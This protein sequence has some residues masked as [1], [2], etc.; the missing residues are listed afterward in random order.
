MIQRYEID[1]HSVTMYEVADGGYVKWDDVKD[2]LE[3]RDLS[4]T[5]RPE[6]YKWVDV[7]FKEDSCCNRGSIEDNVL[8]VDCGD[9]YMYRDN[10]YN[11][12][13]KWKY[14]SKLDNPWEKQ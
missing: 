2:Q 7:W 8:Q 1:C 13:V 11:G 10:I 9:N 4:E 6:D 5:C 14:C 3:W 12:T